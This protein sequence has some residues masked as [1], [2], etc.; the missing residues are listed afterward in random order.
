MKTK[1]Q[2]L[3][4]KAR[5]IKKN[6]LIDQY[7]GQP[8]SVSNAGFII[9]KFHTYQAFLERMKRTGKRYKVNN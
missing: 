9:S 5:N 7:K 1:R 2:K 4:E 6:N 3:Y 8:L